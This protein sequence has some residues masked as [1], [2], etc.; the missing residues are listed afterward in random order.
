VRGRTDRL[1]QGFSQMSASARRGV[2]APPFGRPKRPA[3]PPLCSPAEGKHAGSSPP[4]PAV[5]LPWP[6]RLL[7]RFYQHGRMVGSSVACPRRARIWNRVRHKWLLAPA[8]IRSAGDHQ[9]TQLSLVSCPRFEPATVS[10]GSRTCR[11]VSPAPSWRIRPARLLGPGA[12]QPESVGSRLLSLLQ[13]ALNQT[14]SANSGTSEKPNCRRHSSGRLGGSRPQ[15]S[16]VFLSERRFLSGAWGLAHLLYKLFW[17]R[18]QRLGLVENP[19]S[20]HPLRLLF[21]A[22]D[23]AYTLIQPQDWHPG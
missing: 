7:P 21:S 22:A 17:P 10:A 18:I 8:T 14:L 2:V 1:P 13:S 4:E 20:R 12:R 11:S 3:Q 9:G 23:I 5:E 15:R 19:E 16:A 6:M